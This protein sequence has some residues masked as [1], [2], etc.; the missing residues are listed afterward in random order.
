[1]NTGHQ[2]INEVAIILE[3]TLLCLNQAGYINVHIKVY[4]HQKVIIYK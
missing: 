3:K 2:E 4:E 1:M